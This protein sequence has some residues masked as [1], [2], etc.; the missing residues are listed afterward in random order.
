MATKKQPEKKVKRVTRI[1]KDAHSP[2]FIDKPAKKAPEK[3]T[4]PARSNGKHPG[5]RPSKYNPEICKTLPDMFKEGQS[6][7]EVATELGIS[8]V[9]YYQ[10][11][12]DYPEFLN[13]STRG[14]QISQSWWEKQGRTNLFDESEFGEGSGVNRRFNDR[15]WSKNMACRFRKDWTEKQEI[16]VT[17]K[18]GNDRSFTI[19]FAKPKE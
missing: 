3:K 6:V 13:A 4:I 10:W 1:V 12:K 5:G 19:T 11:E 8:V 2:D 9:T 16:G 7:C 17:D 15:L 14:K 18:D